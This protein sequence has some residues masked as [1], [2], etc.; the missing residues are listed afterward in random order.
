M[1]TPREEECK[2]FHDEG[3][4]PVT[5]EEVAGYA[6]VSP[7]SVS[8]VLNHPEK[9]SAK[10]KTKVLKAFEELNYLPHGGARALASRRSHMIGAV[11]P[12]LSWAIFATMVQALQTRLYASQH[13]LIL[14]SSEY[15]LEREYEQARNF[16]ERRVDGLVL[17]GGE[18]HP[19]LYA[20]LARTGVPYV[21]TFCY[22]MSRDRP[23]IGI[24][25]AKGAYDLTGH[26]VELGHRQFGFL[27][28]PIRGNDRVAARLRGMQTC[29]SDHGI[30]FPEDRIIEVPY[31]LSEGRNG[32]RS[33]IQSFPGMT[34]LVCSTDVL[35]IG[36][37]ME[38]QDMGIEIPGKLS[39]TGFDDLDL[40]SQI[41]PKLSTVHIPANQ[42]GIRAA[43][44]LLAQVDG[45]A[46]PMNTH[47]DANVLIR[48]STGLA[49]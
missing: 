36:A 4:K 16:I 33:L 9:V 18:H 2:P 27:T 25:N 40:A 12:T 7:S 42:I 43:E 17:I 38:A 22:S 20:L 10:I 47:L 35:A 31:G 8:R 39:V 30:D 48:G 41:R 19:D 23:S 45:R 49:P 3:N 11:V 15:D 34:A 44:F 14:A 24:D 13:Q 28:S 5:L 32:L 1:K 29:L 21:N 37:I 46:V 26:L 6:G